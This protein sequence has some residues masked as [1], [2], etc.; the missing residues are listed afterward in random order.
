MSDIKQ[1]LAD[2]KNARQEPSEHCAEGDMH[3]FQFMMH[4]DSTDSS[5][6]F[7]RCPN[8]REV[9]EQKTMRKGMNK[10]LWANES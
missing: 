1:M 9:V 4:S 8:C 7:F 6:N 10:A 2:M 5:S 3:D